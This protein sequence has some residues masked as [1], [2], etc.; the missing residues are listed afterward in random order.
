MKEYQ[1]TNDQIDYIFYNEEMTDIIVVSKSGSIYTI[2]IKAEKY[3]F[4]EGLEDEEN[5]EVQ[6]KEKKILD[7]EANLVCSYN[8]SRIVFIGELHDPNYFVSI[9]ENGRLMVLSL[10]NN[11]KLTEIDLN[12]KCTCACLSLEKNFIF[13]GTEQGCV[14]IID[15]EELSAPRCVWVKKITLKKGIKAIEVSLDGKMIAVTLNESREL[16][17]MSGE[18]DKD[19]GFYG[20]VK[21]T[22]TV[23]SIGWTNI[24]K[25]P[26]PDE[27]THMVE[28]CIRNGLL[29]AVLPPLNMEVQPELKPFDDQNLLQFGKRVD[30]DM[31]ILAIDKA[32]GDIWMSGQQLLFNKY[33]QPIKYL[34]KMEKKP[35]P[36]FPPS[37]VI[38]GHEL[39]SNILQWIPSQNKLLSGGKDG[40]VMLIDP[41]ANDSQEIFKVHNLSKGGVSYCTASSV[42]PV[43]YSG[44]FDG[45]IL[46]NK[47][48][49]FE[50]K[51][52]ETG[53]K[54]FDHSLKNLDTIELLADEDIK[55]YK[56]LLEEEHRRMKDDERREVQ[57]EMKKEL[58]IIRAKLRDLLTK[59]Q[60]AE[61]LEKLERDKFCLDTRLRDKILSEA[62]QEVE[63]I[64]KQA[65]FTNL[66]EEL[67]HKNIER[68]TYKKMET[69][70]KTLTGFEENTIVFNFVIRT[71]D[72]ESDKKLKILKN[73]RFMEKKEQEWRRDKKIPEYINLRK[74]SRKPIGY[75][76]NAFPGEQK[77][78]LLD[79]AKREEE[80]QQIKMMASM[81][82]GLVGALKNMDEEESDRPK[83]TGYRLKR[84]K[85]H[86]RKQKK[87]LGVQM[88]TDDPIDGNKTDDPNFY[89]EDTDI[90]EDWGYMYGALDLFTTK[91]KK[92]Q[93]LILKNI[94]LMIKKT[95][96]KEF[97]YFVKRRSDQV[98]QIAERNK[99]INE[100]LV[101]LE[102]HEKNFQPKPNII[103]MPEKILDVTPDEIGITQYE[104]KKQRADNEKK[105]QAEEE[106]KRQRASD[107]AGVRALKQMMNNTLE[108]KKENKLVEELVEEDWMQKPE[109]EM[110]SD[111]KTKLE[112][113]RAK[114]AKLEEE[115]SKFDQK[116]KKFLL[117]FFSENSEE[118][119][120]GAE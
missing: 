61:P 80:R 74:M 118:V 109:D 29:I 92:I 31:K 66:R 28:V 115:K 59:N 56:V 35:K 110:T 1:F 42:Y 50:V 94:I 83:A 79:H 67:Y 104:T 98:E 3:D 13:V 93:I 49:D 108:E 41:N 25:N 73:L 14:K 7:E 37:K 44:G 26:V 64:R 75:I 52:S 15:L 38:F 5:E 100:I 86:Q 116:I 10:E 81:D 27:Y 65:E 33:E 46:V 24:T 112:N 21:M 6:E 99:E 96:N 39:E 18:H 95:F 77:M 45:S 48:E 58:L 87:M 102:R 9:G 22:G 17:I 30:H 111:E 19:F 120:T 63:K 85:R 53:D 36:P 82:S 32:S 23:E 2:P 4:N 84:Q 70:L 51:P 117:T 71:K 114:K 12:C 11:E 62:E 20:S 105:R 119:G 88:N 8:N 101:K 34:P 60:E 78:I 72:T 90:A 54:N 68:N 97:E 76:V 43:V 40:S 91:R 113:F 47:R 16:I 89:G 55:F 106:R 57:S 69:K 107:D 103:E